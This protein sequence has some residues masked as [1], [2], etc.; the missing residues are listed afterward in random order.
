[1]SG[2]TLRVPVLTL[3]RRPGT[4]H[5]LRA[6]CDVDGLAVGEVGV[7][8]GEPV[9]VDVVLEA[10]NDAITVSG[11][12]TAAF[13][14]PCRRCLEDVRGELEVDV[15]EVFE[16][17]PTEGET[18]L[19]DVDHIDLGDLVRDSVLVGLPLAPLCR[20]DCAG[21]APDRFPTGPAEAPSRDPRWAA[22]DRL[23]LG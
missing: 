21:P 5:P 20:A 17:H 1:V 14:G 8:A 18:Y 9:E 4:R 6:A 7:P 11:T 10:I 3:L 13:A 12:I 15:H 16:R 22:L 19:L 23:D 2:P